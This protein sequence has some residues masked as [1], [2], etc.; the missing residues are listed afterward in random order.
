MDDQRLGDLASQANVHRQRQVDPRRAHIRQPV[1]GQGG[2]VRDDSDDFRSPDLRPEDRGHV[3][4][5]LRHRETSEA[6]YTACHALDVSLL[7][8]LHQTDLM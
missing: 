7:G 3:V 8:E 2:L 4:P 5:Q 1:D 6:V